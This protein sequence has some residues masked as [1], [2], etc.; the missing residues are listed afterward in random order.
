MITF[1]DFDSFFFSGQ[2]PAPPQ[3]TG[4]LSHDLVKPDEVKFGKKSGFRLPC[5]ASGSNLRWSWR[6]NGTRILYGAEYSLG[7][8]G[9]LT[10]HYLEAKNSGSYQC[11]VEDTVT[12]KVTFSRKLKV[13]VTCEN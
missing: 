1:S 2:L 7:A 13:A 5:E 12:V 10:G 3:I 4:F 8:D 9:S 11:I 6:H